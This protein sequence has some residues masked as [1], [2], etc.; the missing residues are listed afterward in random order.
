MLLCAEALALARAGAPLLQLRRR[1]N[2]KRRR[3]KTA[4]REAKRKC[5]VNP[6]CF[7]R[8]ILV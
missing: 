1:G 8:I 7:L 3:S 5:A 2:R 6:A 4:K